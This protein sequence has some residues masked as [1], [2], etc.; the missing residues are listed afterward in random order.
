MLL[1]LLVLPVLPVLLV[2]VRRRRPR[3]AVANMLLVPY[4]C[5]QS[6]PPRLVPGRAGEKGDDD[7]CCRRCALLAAARKKS[8]EC[9][10][11]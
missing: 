4:R 3:P 5:L 9:A 7:S 6:C 1:V 10:R 11:S 8:T 2:L